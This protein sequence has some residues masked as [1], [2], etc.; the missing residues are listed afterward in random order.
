[1]RIVKRIGM[2][3]VAVFALSAVAATAASATEGP[4]WR[5]NGKTLAAGESRLLLATA[6]KEFTLEAKNA[7][8][9]IVCKGLRLPT[10]GQMEIIGQGAG[11]GGIS[12]EVIE[13][14]TCVVEGNGAGCTVPGGVIKTVPV[15]NL[16]GYSNAAK[17][18]GVLVLFEP[19]IGSTF[20]H[21]PFSGECTIPLTTVTG[22]VV[23][24][25]RVGGSPVLL[26]P[27]AGIETLH[28][29]VAFPHPNLIFIERGGVL[30]HQKAGLNAFGVGATLTG[31]ALLLVDENGVA[32][33][34]GVFS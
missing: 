12:K 33:P 27:A 16:L 14:T 26:L 10:S 7:G 32:V 20:V 21:I 9:K 5:V 15:F 22:T 24:A 17:T 13:F 29:E 31:I 1:M 11:N 25:A 4:F 23:G 30:R 6:S 19:E 2:V 34:W 28:G 8:V 18:G 3:L